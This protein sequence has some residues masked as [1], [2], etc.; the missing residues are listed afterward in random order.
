MEIWCAPRAMPIM[1]LKESPMMTMYAM[2]EPHRYSS[3]ISESAAP[4]VYVTTRTLMV[5][6]VAFSIQSRPEQLVLDATEQHM[7]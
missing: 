4:A 1:G 3:M 5:A 6:V 7:L 2:Q